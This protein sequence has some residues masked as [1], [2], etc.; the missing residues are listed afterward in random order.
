MTRVDFYIL[1][2]GAKPPE[3]ALM[4]ACKLCDKAVGAGHRVYILAPDG[5]TVERI[6]SLLWSFRQ[7][8]FIAHERAGTA[9]EEPLPPVLIGSTEPPATHQEV[10][11]SLAPDVPTFFSRY[12]RVLEIVDGD[13]AQ[14]AKSRERYK[15]YRDRGYELASHN[16]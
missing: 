6:D 8:S 12:E 13:S 11:I 15:F 3:G 14:R 7:G 1:P 2:E 4:T 10:L 5:D 16:L 9:L